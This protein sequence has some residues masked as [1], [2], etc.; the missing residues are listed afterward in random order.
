MKKI[1]A[2]VFLL[3]T[4]VVTFAQTMSDVGLLNTR[5]YSSLFGFQNGNV[6]HTS[7]Y[8]MAATRADRRNFANLSENEVQ[9]DTPLEFTLLSY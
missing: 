8:V 1:F 4:L 2:V 5:A 6:S 3:L 7:K 9:I